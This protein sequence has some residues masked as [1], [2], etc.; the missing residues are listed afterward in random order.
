MTDIIA[1]ILAAKKALGALPKPSIER[2]I[3][4]APGMD[5]SYRWESKRILWITRAH[6][7]A[8]KADAKAPDDLNPLIARLF[9]IPVEYFFWKDHGDLWRD[10]G[11]LFA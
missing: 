2:I 10:F 4:G 6:W 1:E 7:E 8:L 3:V 5:K 9:G 11:R